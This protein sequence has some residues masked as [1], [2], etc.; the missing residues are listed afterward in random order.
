MPSPAGYIQ[1]LAWEALLS[2]L[3]AGPE[4]F[5][6]PAPVSY[7]GGRNVR[8]SQWLY[9]GD[10][11]TPAHR[12]VT[13]PRP[14]RFQTVQAAQNIHVP[15]QPACTR[16]TTGL[17]AAARCH[18]GPGLISQSPPRLRPTGPRRCR[19]PH[20][21]THRAVGTRHSESRASRI[22]N[23][24][25]DG[26]TR[27]RQPLLGITSMC[28]TGLALGRAGG[29]R[30]ERTLRRVNPA[31]RSESVEEQS[32][33]VSPFS[34]HG[35]LRRKSGPPPPATGHRTVR[36]R[37]RDVGGKSDA[38]R[39]EAPKKVPPDGRTSQAA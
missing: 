21:P 17:A 3:R 22:R 32:A 19:R 20:G 9:R 35:V 30:H 28:T 8:S 15:A 26:R 33:R 18:G 5:L 25:S 7:I 23:H 27:T 34:P 2:T 39:S 38:G 4:L 10:A 11:F 12:C 16:L 14:A 37:A 31:Q 1:S 6:S 29:P 36:H 13:C 24:M